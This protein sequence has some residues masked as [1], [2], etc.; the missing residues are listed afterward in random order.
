MEELA[1]HTHYMPP[2]WR[3]R[4]AAY[5]TRDEL[6]QFFQYK[7]TLV[8]REMLSVL[9]TPLILCVHMPAAVPQILDFLR[10]TTVRP[11]YRAPLPA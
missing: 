7:A 10:D 4:Q 5:D 8:A 11:V 2:R 9:L 3:G 6:L 1:T